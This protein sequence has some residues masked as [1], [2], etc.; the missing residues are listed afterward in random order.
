MSDP[1]YPPGP[2][3]PLP[4]YRRFYDLYDGYMPRTPTYPDRYYEY[5]DSRYDVPNPRDYPPIYS[6]DLD[7]RYYMRS[8]LIPPSR[9]RRIIYYANLPEVVRTPPSV[10][11]RYRSY[12]RYDPYYDPYAARMMSA[13][14]KPR[15]ERQMAT[16]EYGMPNRRLLEVK[17]IR[18]QKNDKKTELNKE[19]EVDRKDH[20]PITREY[21]YR[22]GSSYYQ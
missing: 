11:L 14:R 18:D 9:N 12:D 22:P 13:Y 17:G 19:V 20:L 4:E 21:S 1:L 3:D 2:I 5:P 8:D 7:D 6:N 10:D 16:R 15:L